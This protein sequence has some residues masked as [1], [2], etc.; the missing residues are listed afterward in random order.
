[1]HTLIPDIALVYSETV[2]MR[3]AIRTITIGIRTGRI[4]A[5]GGFCV[6]VP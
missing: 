5:V 3:T 4:P 2:T 1:M 6:M